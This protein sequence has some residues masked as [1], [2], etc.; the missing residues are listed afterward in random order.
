MKTLITKRLYLRALKPTDLK[1]FNA[2]AKKP[3]IG[4]AAGWKPHESLE[5]SRKILNMMIHESEV[6][7]ITLIDDD[8]LIGTI[9]LHVRHFDNAMANRKEIGYV[10]D[11]KYW[12]QGLMTE[13][14]LKVIA[15]GFDTLEL[16]EIECGH[17]K[18]NLRSKRVIEK[19][20]F[21]YDHIEI[22]KDAY[23]KDIEVLMYKLTKDRYKGLKCYD[24]FKAKI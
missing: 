21:I 15:Y 8:T 10:L 6:W 12:H 17:H 11:D 4:P 20:N 13:A 5:E 23:Q 16:D 2:Y 14:V 9:G 24:E 18:D 1:A 7:G 22:R 3:H 19:T